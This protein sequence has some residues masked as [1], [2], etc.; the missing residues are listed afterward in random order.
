MAEPGRMAVGDGPKMERRTY[1]SVTDVACRC[2]YLQRRAEDPD[3]PIA[4]DETTGEFQFTYGGA[5]LIIYHCPF[6]GGAAPK[7]KRPL[8][9]AV[10]PS[11]EEERLANL[12]TPLSTIGSALKRLGKPEHDDPH[13]LRTTSG[14]KDGRPIMQRYRTLTYERLSE[15]ADVQIVERADRSIHWQLSGKPLARLNKRDC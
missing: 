12:L 4:F 6:C 8:L 9:F 11:E 5:T 3:I 14:G 10:V 13:G 1:A 7:S 2:D 15:V